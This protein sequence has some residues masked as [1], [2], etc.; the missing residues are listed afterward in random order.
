MSAD[1]IAALSVC[2]PVVVFIT[3]LMIDLIVDG[4]E[5]AL[6]PRGLRW[7]PLVWNAV[8]ERLH[9]AAL[10]V[11][12]PER[13]AAFKSDRVLRLE[14]LDRS[15]R[16]WADVGVKAGHGEPPRWVPARNGREEFGRWEPYSE[17]KHAPAVCPC[18]YGEECAVWCGLGHGRGDCPAHSSPGVRYDAP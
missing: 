16:L 11:L 12:W 14:E 9:R 18:G 8:K 7:L 5:H 2:V 6:W 15:W 17:T 1:E 4:S 13:L 10:R 3:L